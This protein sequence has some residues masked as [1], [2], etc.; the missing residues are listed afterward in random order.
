LTDIASMTED[1]VRRDWIAWSDIVQ[2]VSE[3]RWQYR[4][5]QRSHEARCRR[6]LAAAFY[7][8]CN[9]AFEQTGEYSVAVVQS[10]QNNPKGKSGC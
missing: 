3:G 5:G 2:L 10:T 1:D 8:R 4:S 6:G 9:V 7:A